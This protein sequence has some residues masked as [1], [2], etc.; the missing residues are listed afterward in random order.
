MGIQLGSNFTVNTSLPLDD[1]TVVADVTARDAIDSG[2]RYEGLLVYVEADATNYQLVGGITNGDWAELSGGGGAGGLLNYITNSK[3]E[4]DTTDWFTYLSSSPG[5]VPV[6]CTPGTGVDIVFDRTTTNP[7][8]GVGSFRIANG[9]GSIGEGFGTAFTIQRGDRGQKFRATADFEIVSGSYGSGSVSVTSDLACFI[10]DVTN[11]V[12][13]SRSVNYR[14][15]VDAGASTG[16]LDMEF[17][18]PTN[19]TSFRFLV[20]VATT[21]TGY[22]LT[23][24][25]FLLTRAD[26]NNG[27]LKLVSTPQSPTTVTSSGITYVEKT[28]ARQVIYVQSASGAVQVTNVPQI[29]AAQ[30]YG[31]ELWVIGTS[32]SN[33][34][35]ITGNGSGVSLKSDWASFNGNVLKL[36]WNGSLWL[37]VGRNQRDIKPTDNYLEFVSGDASAE[38]TSRLWVTYKDAAGAQPVDATGG[39]PTVTFTRSASSPLEGLGSYLFTKPA[40]NTQGEGVAIEIE[41]PVAAYGKMLTFTGDVSLVSGTY[42]EGSQTTPS[43]VTLYFIAVTAGTVIQPAAYRI[44]PNAVGVGGVIQ[45]E[46][47]TLSTA[48]TYRIVFHCATTSASAYELK[49]DNLKLSRSRITRGALITDP[50]AYTPTVAGLGTIANVNVTYRRVGSNLE[51]TGSLDSGTPTATPLYISLPSGLSMP[52]RTTPQQ[53]GLGTR[54]GGT[55]TYNKDLTI[56]NGSFSTTQVG[57][58]IREGTSATNPSVVQNGDTLFASGNVFVFQFSVPIAGWSSSQQLSSDAGLRLVAAKYQCSTAD[59]TQGSVLNNINYDTRVYDTHNAVTTSATDWRFTAPESGYYAVSISNNYASGSTSGVYLYRNGSVVETVAGAGVANGVTG[60]GSTTVFLSAGD[61][62]AFN[63]ASGSTSTLTA[64][65][66]LNYVVI[67]KIQSPQ[68]LA[69]SETVAFRATTATATV[70]SS[71]SDVSW[72]VVADN[73]HG[74]FVSP[75]FTVPVAGRYSVSAQIF[76]GWASATINQT[77]Q[78]ALLVNGSQ[79]ANDITYAQITGGTNVT[80]KINLHDL[81]LAAGAVVKLQVAGTMTSPGINPSATQNYFSMIRVGV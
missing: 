68:Q 49:F 38:T 20:H 71:L 66:N 42:A 77:Y 72:S 9:A 3:A 1:R 57:V 55:A 41:L 21:N 4:V 26:Q 29:S 10:F 33:Y 40:S 23:F 79:V 5:A 81:V 19:S 32:N 6:T 59:V 78:I 62:I 27:D 14:I 46:F 35:I 64:S 50:V 76:A 67:Q 25:N 13:L 54:F 44:I 70:T 61:Y 34:I 12:T 24:D 65:T 2:K 16:R 69:A 48:D 37:E 80:V 51:V 30:T 31:R 36:M 56:L 53:V 39:S 15:A 58:G 7:I 8:E 63:N 60:N 75:N 11:N 28:G 47:Q 18:A 73:T 45:A 52:A 74:A 43:D 22:T 17:T